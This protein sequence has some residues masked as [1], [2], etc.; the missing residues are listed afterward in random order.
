MTVGHVFQFGDARAH[1]F[2]A[3]AIEQFEQVPFTDIA[4]A[5]LGVEI[6]FLIGAGAH[7]GQQQVDHVFTALAL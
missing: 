3:I 7:V 4:R 1:L 5:V 6:A 2:H